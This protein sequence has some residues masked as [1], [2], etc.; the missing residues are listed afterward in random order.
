[1]G[2]ARSYNA[3]RLTGFPLFFA[4]AAS[5]VSGSVNQVKYLVHF[6]ALPTGKVL[7]PSRDNLLEGVTAQL[8]GRSRDV[9]LVR[10]SAGLLAAAATGSLIGVWAGDL[11]LVSTES[12]LGLST[13][14]LDTLSIVATEWFPV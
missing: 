1:M 13:D 2:V 7:C 8:P 4:L 14:G 9:L 6:L 10:A 5:L 3:P 12:L 11:V